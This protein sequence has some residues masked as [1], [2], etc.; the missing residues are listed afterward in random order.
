[1]GF[2]MVF[3]FTV[4]WVPFYK[5][6]N[7]TLAQY[8]SSVFKVFFFFSSKWFHF[9]LC[10]LDIT[11]NGKETLCMC[12]VL[13]C[14]WCL[15]SCFGLWKAS[16]HVSRSLS[17]RVNACRGK[18]GPRIWLTCL[19]Y[20]IYNI[21][22]IGQQF[23]GSCVQPCIIQWW[24]TLRSVVVLYIAEQSQSPAGTNTLLFLQLRYQI[25]GV[26]QT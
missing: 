15:Q 12:S 23:Y 19:P 13:W 11:L 3:P 21:V 17:R 4:Y 14:I 18:S 24:V 6:T 22:H 5:N 26:P 2:D 25:D 10:G 8:V 16:D 20:N 7:F 1:M 9:V